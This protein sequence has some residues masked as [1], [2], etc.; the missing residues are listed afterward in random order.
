MTTVAELEE[1]V[2]ALEDKIELLELGE[3]PVLEPCPECGRDVSR[4][5]RDVHARMHW[6]DHCPEPRLF[7]QAAERYHKLIEVI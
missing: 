4:L 6:G 7:P 2:A 1:R 5:D 3:V